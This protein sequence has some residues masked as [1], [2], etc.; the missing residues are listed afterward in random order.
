VSARFDS[1]VLC[2]SPRSGSTLLCNLLA[3]TGAAGLPDSH[4][5][6]PSLVSWMTDHGIAATKGESERALL[7]RVFKAAI[8]EGSGTTG[9]FG[10]RL[11]RHSFAFFMDKLG[12]LYPGRATD[13]D[14]LEAAFGSTAFLYLTR[15]DKGAQAVSY[16]KAQ[17][18]GLWHVAPDGT[19]LERLSQP[20]EP[21]YDGARI[22]TVV[23][24]MTAYDHDWRAWFAAQ[25]IE[26]LEILYESFSAGPVASLATVLDHLGVDRDVA[27]G[28]EPGVAKL[29]DGISRSWVERFRSEQERES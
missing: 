5:H 15:R 23:A 11:Q 29:S 10:L 21:V 18:T 8:A 28:V 13:R 1:Y 14:R 26:P 3:K 17:Q 25:N 2:T 9:M 20:Q 22:A 19:E 6:E 24:E 4:F 27:R 16:V 12:V 7:E